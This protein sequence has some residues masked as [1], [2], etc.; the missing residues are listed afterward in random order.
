VLLDY[1]SSPLQVE[2]AGEHHVTR[3]E[4]VHPSTGQLLTADGTQFVVGTSTG[5]ALQHL[6]GAK[7]KELP[8][9]G[10]THCSPVRWWDGKIRQTVLAGCEAAKGK[11]LWLVPV[12]GDSPTALTAPNDG[13]TGRDVGDD[14]AWQLPAGTF[15]Q[16]EGG[17]GVLYLAKLNPDGTT[18][19]VSVPN[20]DSRDVVVLGANGGDLDVMAHAPCGGGKSVALY[21]PAA[22]TST[23][24]L[25]PPLNGG[26]VISALLYPD[27]T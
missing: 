22:G 23:V 4:G 6:D 21:D 7:G 8:V 1:S 16:A 9:A 5:L 10:E 3:A 11:Q 19:P 12:N 20:V 17:C 25:G 15:V 14:D 2:L 27:Q 13:K 18:T 24:L 26:G